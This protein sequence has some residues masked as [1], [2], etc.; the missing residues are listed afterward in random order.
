MNALQADG[1]ASA[2]ICSRGVDIRPGRGRITKL[3]VGYVEMSDVYRSLIAAYPGPS[4]SPQ[5]VPVEPLAVE[6]TP[7]NSPERLTG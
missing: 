5:P 1:P 4:R 7:P 2:V 6:K 3:E